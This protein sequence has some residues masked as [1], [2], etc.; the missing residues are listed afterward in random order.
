MCAQKVECKLQYMESQV[1]EA[2]SAL[3]RKHAAMQEAVDK[4]IML[5]DQIG[6]SETKAE[7]AEEKL[8]KEQV[9]R[10]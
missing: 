8:A 3:G 10:N 4:V 9:R 2:Q 6:A 5:E 7:E 1:E